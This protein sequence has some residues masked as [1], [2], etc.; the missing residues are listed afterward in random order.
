MHE[1][2][3]AG[4]DSSP[5]K[6]S[7]YDKEAKATL[8]LS[9]LR[10]EVGVSQRV[11]ADRLGKSQV[12][13]SRLEGRGDFLISTLFDYVDALGGTAGVSISLPKGQFQIVGKRDQH[14][15]Y[16]ELR[17]KDGNPKAVYQKAPKWEHA[18]CADFDAGI[19]PEV[20]FDAAPSSYLSDSA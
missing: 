12:A 1:N 14:F 4:V 13:I 2:R 16:W 7:F 19:G 17:L 10:A 15:G 8:P 5:E 18:T 11:V 3:R 9:A 20:Y 6:V